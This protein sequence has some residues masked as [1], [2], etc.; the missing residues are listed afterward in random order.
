M[1]YVPDETEQCGFYECSECGSRFLDLRIAPSLVCPYCGEEPD[2]ELGPDD[3]M[4]EMKECAKLIKMLEGEEV[5]KYDTL[6]S[7]ALTGG[8]YSWI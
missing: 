7:L 1:F 4:P 5:E 8:D 6:L 2:M 3:E